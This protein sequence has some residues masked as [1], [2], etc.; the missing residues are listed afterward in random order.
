MRNY[1]ELF[2]HK[3]VYHLAVLFS[4][5]SN[6][7]TILVEDS[8]PDEGA[9]SRCLSRIGFRV[10]RTIT[11]TNQEALS[12]LFDRL[13]YISSI[14]YK[15]NHKPATIICC[16]KC[17]LDHYISFEKTRVLFILSDD[18]IDPEVNGFERTELLFQ[19]IWDNKS[20]AGYMLENLKYRG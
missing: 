4:K 6:I 8:L 14:A 19:T 18:G 7:S 17:D 16:N 13:F 3:V 10:R 5:E 2:I 1:H 20:I 11:N 15:K 9:L 12:M